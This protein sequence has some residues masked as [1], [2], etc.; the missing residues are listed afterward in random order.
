MAVKIRLSRIGK[1]HV[2]MYRVIAVDSRVKRDGACLSNIGTYDAVKGIVVCFDGALY[3]EWISKGAQPTDSAKRIYKKFKK[4]DV[5]ASSSPAQKNA[6]PAS[7]VAKRKPAQKSAAAV[8][9][10]EARSEA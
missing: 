3:D 9:A 1:K 5:A 2:P 8:E 7:V 10:Q 6:E 4:T